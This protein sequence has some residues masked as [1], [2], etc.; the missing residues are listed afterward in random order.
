MS[1]RERGNEEEEEEEE[2]EGEI[3]CEGRRKTGRGKEGGTQR[4]KGQHCCTI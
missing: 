4:R 2:E 1:E 3:E